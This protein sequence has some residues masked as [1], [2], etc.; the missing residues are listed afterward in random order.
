VADEAE[1]RSEI[2]SLSGNLSRAK[3]REDQLNE[4]LRRLSQS[5]VEAAEETKRFREEGVS[6]QQELRAAK[7]ETERISLELQSVTL[8]KEKLVNQNARAAADLQARTELEIAKNVAA[9]ESA[10]HKQEL[11]AANALITCLS[12]QLES[13]ISPTNA[14]ERRPADETNSARKESRGA[15]HK[16][17][18]ILPVEAAQGD[19]KLK[20]F[21]RNVQITRTRRL[22][23]GLYLT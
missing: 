3:S 4:E 20:S 22:F 5:L 21:L 7:S 12:A 9:D 19:N 17:L 15:G 13:K 18:R 16:E 1:L 11:D 14:Y 6:L 2:A 23:C 10:S 8:N